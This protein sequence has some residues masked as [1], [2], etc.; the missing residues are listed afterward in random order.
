M[1]TSEP[2]T[3]STSS[4]STTTSTTTGS[5]GASTFDVGVDKDLGP[6]TPEG[7]KGKI[8]FLFVI[9]RADVMEVVQEQLIASFPKFIETIAAKF[10]DFDYHIMVVGSGDVWGQKICTSDCPVIDCS[11]GEPCCWVKDY[12]CGLLGLVTECDHTKGAGS[13]FPAGY[14]ASNHPCPIADNRRYMTKGQPDLEGTFACSA[15][16]GIGGR[17]MI[18]DN[19]VNA[20][21]PYLNGPGGCNEGFLRDDALL[22][23]TLVTPGSDTFSK[24]P[25]ELWGEMV[26]KAKHDDPEAV[27]MLV[28]GNGACPDYDQPCQMALEFPYHYIEDGLV[29][30]YGP[31]FDAASDLA[32]EACEQLVPQ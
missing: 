23:V 1:T 30:D 21:S 28:I 32:F 8:D 15:R 29:D 6:A 24:W 12:P 18:G 3:T 4:T 9:S 27:V 7:C 5:S 13:V 10:D 22:M 25:P 14:G 19:L 17:N 11:E 26:R 20:V 31:A 16:V 2:A